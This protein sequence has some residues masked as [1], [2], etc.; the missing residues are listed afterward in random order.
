MV[1][2][3]CRSLELVEGEN[4]MSVSSQRHDIR[5]AQNISPLTQYLGYYRP[6]SC[7]APTSFARVKALAAFS[8]FSI[9]YKY[10]SRN[11]HYSPFMCQQVKLSI[12]LS[13]CNGFGIQD[14]RVYLFI[15][16]AG[17]RIFALQCSQSFL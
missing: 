4:A 6:V 14:K 5:G 9:R 7:L 8:M 16:G 10:L 2:S 17:W 3:C 12:Q 1:E 15:R 13:H 11:S